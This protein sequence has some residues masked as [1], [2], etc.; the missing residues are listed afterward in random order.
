MIDVQDTLADLVTAGPARAQTLDALDLDYCCHGQRTL[1]DACAAAAIDV[2]DVVAQLEASDRSASRSTGWAG[3]GVEA[4]I[5]HIVTVHH[6]LL[7]R[8]A[9]R[10]LE[11]GRKVRDVHGGNHHALFDVVDTLERLWSELAPHLDEEERETFPALRSLADG[12]ATS[13]DLQHLADDHEAA[14]ALLDRLRRAT[15][16]FTVPG[17]G[18]ASFRAFYGGLA[19]LDADTRLHVHKENNVLFPAVTGS[20]RRVAS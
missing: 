10:L 19:E 1:I 6:Q 9:P 8:E 3:L 17:D 5:D 13:I 11:L 15:A 14:G 18:C 20:R 4:L 2:W 16:S 7:R 12:S